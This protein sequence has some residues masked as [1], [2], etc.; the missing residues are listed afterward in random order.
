MRKEKSHVA[1]ISWNLALKIPLSSNRLNRELLVF[2]QK[3]GH[4]DILIIISKT[5]K[6][7]ITYYGHVNYFV[8]YHSKYKRKNIP[9]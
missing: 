4:S 7:L 9:T 8:L 5:G 6:I 3:K 2:R 1:R